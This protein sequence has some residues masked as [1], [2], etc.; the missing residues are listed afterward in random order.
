MSKYDKRIPDPRFQ[1]GYRVEFDH[2]AYMRAMRAKRKAN[3]TEYRFSLNDNLKRLYGITLDQFE[4]MASDQAGVCAIC[5]RP[6]TASSGRARHPP[7][8]QVDHCHTTGKIRG[9]LCHNCN[10]MIAN[11]QKTGIPLDDLFHKSKL[12]LHS[13]IPGVE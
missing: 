13:F 1:S 2:V 9:L 8:L 10:A 3:G 7:R 4:A 11:A 12:Y 5:G 6:P